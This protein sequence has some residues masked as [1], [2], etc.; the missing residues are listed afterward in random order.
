VSYR[1]P[2]VVPEPTIV[3]FGEWV[4]RLDAT[5]GKRVWYQH[6]PSSSSNAIV[7]IVVSVDRVVVAANRSFVCLALDSGQPIWTASAP[8]Y[9][10]ALAVVEGMVLVGGGGEA[11]GF[12]LA[13][14]TS[15]WHEPFKNLGS[16]PV[17]IAAG[18]VVSA[19]VPYG[20]GVA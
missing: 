15:R 7:R 16:S 6:L 9:I 19:P 8:F 20:K 4:F 14:G 1:D 3:A 17:T 5:T 11:A 12:D 10:T 2:A 18:A 13:T